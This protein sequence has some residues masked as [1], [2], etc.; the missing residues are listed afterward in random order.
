LADTAGIHVGT[1]RRV[2]CLCAPVEV[3]LLDAARYLEER[4][5]ELFFKLVGALES[6]LHTLYEIVRHLSLP[7]VGQDRI[8]DAEPF[9]ALAS[10]QGAHAGIA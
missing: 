1:L 10:S 6:P 7:S 5:L 9:A 8:L 3:Q 2:A 4:V